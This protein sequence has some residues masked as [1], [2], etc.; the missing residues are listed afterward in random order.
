MNGRATG[1]GESTGH[2]H[3]GRPVPDAGM[4]TT[5][6]A[7]VNRSESVRRISTASALRMRSRFGGA[8]VVQNRR[9]PR[10]WGTSAIIFEALGAIRVTTR[11]FSWVAILFGRRETG[12][13][14]CPGTRFRTDR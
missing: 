7:V 3:R 12:V 1:W 9:D 5:S 4:G 13:R 14:V 11:A 10:V 8:A 2:T 6:S